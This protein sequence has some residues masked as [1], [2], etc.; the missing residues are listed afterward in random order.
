MDGRDIIL[1][2]KNSQ[3][4]LA[5]ETLYKTEAGRVLWDKY[6]NNKSHDVYIVTKGK[7]D[8][9]ASGATFANVEKEYFTRK[10]SKKVNGKTVSTTIFDFG[11]EGFDDFR[12]LQGKELVNA[13]RDISIVAFGEEWLAFKDEYQ[14]AETIY[15]EFKS[16]IDMSKKGQRDPTREHSDYGIKFEENSEG[17]VKNLYILEGSP[18][19]IIL[20]QLV[21][22]AEKQKNQS[23]VDALKEILKNVVNKEA[24]E[25]K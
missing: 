25:R 17:Y 23:A 21:S 10:G 3:I 15:H 1:V 11:D 8:Q 4:I 18:M 19:S 16:H 24:F 5:K 2:M 14:N 9:D 6:A 13:D 22:V 7:L 12:S 20:T